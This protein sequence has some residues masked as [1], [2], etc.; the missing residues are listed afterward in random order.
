MVREWRLLRHCVH[1][2]VSSLLIWIANILWCSFTLNKHGVGFRSW[3][4]EHFQ[5]NSEIRW[6]P[7]D[8]PRKGLHHDV[9]RNSDLLHVGWNT[10]VRFP[11]ATGILFLPLSTQT[12]SRVRQAP[13]EYLGLFLGAIIGW[14]VK[15]KYSSY[16]Y[17][18]SRLRMKFYTWTADLLSRDW[19][20]AAYVFAGQESRKC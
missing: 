7:A 8:I 6:A 4:T 9:R 2:D 12:P 15:W 3:N 10:G 5:V 11:T 16:S 13:K 19:L 1:N 20:M 18:M 17:V 14:N